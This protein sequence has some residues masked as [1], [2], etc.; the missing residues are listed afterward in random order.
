MECRK[1]REMGVEIDDV[2]V[3]QEQIEEVPISQVDW[4][5]RLRRSTRKSNIFTT[6]SNV[7]KCII[8]NEGKG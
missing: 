7:P 3:T 2:E 4:E 8:C 1:K 6:R 5:I